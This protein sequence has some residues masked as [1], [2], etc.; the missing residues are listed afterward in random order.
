MTA[1][2]PVAAVLIALFRLI[3]IAIHFLEFSRAVPKGRGRARTAIQLANRC[4]GIILYRIPDDLAE[5]VRKDILEDEHRQIET[6]LVGGSIALAAWTQLFVSSASS[7]A[8]RLSGTTLSLL[9]TGASVLLVVPLLFR[10][11]GRLVTAS[12]RGL[13]T[14]AGFGAVALSLGS[15]IVD[16]RDGWQ[17]PR[18]LRLGSEQAHAEATHTPGRLDSSDLGW[19]ATA[20]K[21]GGGL[22][23]LE[24]GREAAAWCGR[25]RRGCPGGR[26]PGGGGGRLHPRFAGAR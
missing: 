8:N 2:F 4:T 14:Y 17:E 22:D 18:G 10:T 12:Y 11:A 26:R 13:A 21:D 9:F 6:V 3:P 20:R 5:A 25:A 7:P 1:V 19:T 24:R 23:A 15:A 16:L